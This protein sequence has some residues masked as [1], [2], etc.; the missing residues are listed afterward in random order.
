MKGSYAAGVSNTGCTACP[1]GHNQTLQG[2]GEC[3]ECPVGTICK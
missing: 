2:Q 1:E 3:K